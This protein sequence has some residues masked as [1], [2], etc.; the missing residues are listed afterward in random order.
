[1][2]SLI[3]TIII[4]IVVYFI[5][6]ILNRSFMKDSPSLSAFPWR[7]WIFGHL[8]V[9]AF[10]GGL[11]DALQ[12]TIFGGNW[13]LLGASVG[14]MQWIVLKRYIPINNIW[15]ALSTLGWAAIPFFHNSLLGPNPL[16]W[17]ITGFL[18]GTLQWVY[19]KTI[20][21]GTVSWILSNSVAWTVGGTLGIYS[22]LLWQLWIDNPIFDN[23]IVRCGITGLIVGVILG[24]AMATMKQ[25]PGDQE[26]A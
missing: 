9:V 10:F 15:A 19:L 21:R 6:A 8:I 5:T 4:A 11:T 14:I 25:I 3:I 20:G 23:V 24:I 22:N 16:G 7:S 2:L 1:M 17:F 18:V 12:R 13:V 26:E